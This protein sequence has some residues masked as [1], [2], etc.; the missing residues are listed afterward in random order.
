M[1]LSRKRVLAAKLESTAYAAEAAPGWGATFNVFDPIIQPNIESIDR[2]GQ[3]SF[4]YLPSS[5]GL[6]SGTCTFRTELT[7][8]G[9]GPDA[10]VPAW[11]S[12][13]LPACGWVATAGAFAPV[14][15]VPGSNVKTITLGCYVD[16]VL[17]QIRGAMG[18]FVINLENGKPAN[19]DFTFVGAWTSATDAVIINPTYTTVMPLRFANSTLSVSG[20]A[21]CVQS[22]TIDSGNAVSLLPCQAN[23]DAS[24]YKGGFIGGRRPTITMNPEAE[25]VATNTFIADML[26]STQDAFSVALTDST[27]TITIAA[28]KLQPINVQEGEREGLVTDDV[29]F[30]CCRSAAAGDDEL[31]ITFS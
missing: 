2:L 18:S 31:T 21:P 3:G 1:L 7:G 14:S 17:K 24:G 12:T 6:R 30:L 9:A 28:P 25:L 8:D 11:A 29:T 26:A 27:D 20:I 23:T 15:E 19:I 22:I 16:G 10:G 5:T 13:F 4:G